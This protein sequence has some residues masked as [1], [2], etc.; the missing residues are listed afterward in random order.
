VNA[1]QGVQKKK[2]GIEAQKKS[3]RQTRD[4]TKPGV[5]RKEQRKGL[6]LLKG[7]HRG[8]EGGKKGKLFSPEK[9]RHWTAEENQRTGKAQKREKPRMKVLQYEKKKRVGPL[10]QLP[11]D[12]QGE[13]EKGAGEEFPDGKTHLGGRKIYV[14]GEKLSRDLNNG[15]TVPCRGYY[16]PKKNSQKR[17]VRKGRTRKNCSRLRRKADQRVVK[18]D[19]RGGNV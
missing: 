8:G 15:V 11:G 16:N 1:N 5:S 12:K 9:R 7:N 2:K 13:V 3:L 14:G 4:C 17:I 19:L 6:E 10:V 18:E